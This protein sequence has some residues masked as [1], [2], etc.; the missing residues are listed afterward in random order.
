MAEYPEVSFLHVRPFSKLADGY[1][2]RCVISTGVFPTADVT[3]DPVN[4]L[5]EE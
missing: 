5:T 3:T 2:Y 1:E 4:M